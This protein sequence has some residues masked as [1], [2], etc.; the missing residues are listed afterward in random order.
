M[1]SRVAG[2]WQKQARVSIF[3]PPKNSSS[4]LSNSSI[5]I[6]DAVDKFKGGLASLP[7]YFYCSRNAAEPERSDPKLILAS[8]VR[9]L[10]CAQPGSPLFPPAVGKYEE[11]RSTG[12]SWKSP[13]GTLSLDESCELILQLVD[14]RDMTTIVIDALDECDVKMRSELLDALQTILQDAE[15]LVKIFVSSRDDGDIKHRLQDFPNLAIE[16]GRNLDD[17]STFVRSETE[18]LIKRGRLLR[19]SRAKDGLRD[20]VIREVI[21]KAEGM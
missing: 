3:I 9:Q 13:L 5:V 19:N 16:S 2:N 8:I 11:A 15:S 1:A 10:A 17:I 12:S 14:H 6:K 21:E 7:A 18:R 4:S 20:L